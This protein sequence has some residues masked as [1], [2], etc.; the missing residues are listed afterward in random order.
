MATNSAKRKAIEELKGE[1]ELK[2]ETLKAAQIMLEKQ[3]HEGLGE[4]IKQTLRKKDEN[5][6]FWQKLR[7]N[8]AKL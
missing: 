4:E 5:K 6:T 1:I 8:F 7:D 2:G 3:L